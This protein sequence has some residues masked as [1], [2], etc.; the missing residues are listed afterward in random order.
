MLPGIRYALLAAFF[1]GISTPF[2]KILLRHCEPV[3]LASLL[4]LG[5]GIGLFV[6]AAIQH[7]GKRNFSWGFSLNRSDL[8]NLAGAIL[9]GGVV[10]PVLL[11]IGLNHSSSADASLLLN[12]EGVFT[13]ALAWLVFRERFSRMIF[14]G[15]LAIIGGSV[16]LSWKGSIDVSWGSLAVA[17]A[18][19]GWGID[20]NLTRRISR[21]DPI[22]ITTAKGLAA[23]VANFCVALLM[24]QAI[25]S[26]PTI[27][28]ALLLGF[29]SY[30]F[31]L[32]FMIM[33]FRHLGAARTSAYFGTAPFIAAILSIVIFFEPV[34]LFFWIS[35]LLMIGGVSLCLKD[36]VSLKSH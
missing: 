23:G 24:H 10:A 14:L 16:L 31:S 7:L 29:I 36:I 22:Q 9:A 32:I 4:Y 8:P 26:F 20:N 1:F 30:G 17:G 3:M 12:L 2:S 34:D 15:M 33:G 6:Q 28:E 18:C 5:S 25:P 21:S 11:M 27:L 35:C 19:L 13:A